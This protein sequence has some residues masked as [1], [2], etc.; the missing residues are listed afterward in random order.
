M[1]PPGIFLPMSPRAGD[2]ANQMTHSLKIEAA[3]HFSVD[4]LANEG[5]LALFPGSGATPQQ[6]PLAFGKPD[7]ES[8]FHMLLSSRCKTVCK[9]ES[10]V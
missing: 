2:A 4:Y 1:F 6:F 9:T 5:R 10:K 8:G 7:S 3:L